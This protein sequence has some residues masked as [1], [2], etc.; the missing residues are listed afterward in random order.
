VP[1]LIGKGRT[2]FEG[3][4]N[5]ADLELIDSRTFKNGKVS[6]RYAPRS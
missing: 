1:V 3:V 4:T 6:L 5:R 2:P